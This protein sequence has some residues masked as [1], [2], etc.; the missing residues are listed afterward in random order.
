MKMSPYILRHYQAIHTWTGITSGLLLFIGFFA[1]ALV[2]FKPVISEWA[3]PPNDK[4]TQINIKQLDTLTQEILK[5]F[6]QAQKHLVVNFY[7]GVSPLTWLEKG[8][9]NETFMV[10]TQWFASLDHQGQVETHSSTNNE[11][12]YLLDMLHRTAGIAGELGHE[13]AGTYI[14]GIASFLYFIALVSGVII[15]LPTLIKRFFALRT[16]AG[17]SRFWLDS[18]NLVG[19]ASLPFH[20][21]IAI[22][23]VVFSLHDFFYGGLAKIYN[24]KPLFAMPT[25][26]TVEYK[27]D[28]LPKMSILLK[29][30]EEYAPEHKIHQIKLSG[31][32]S[33]NPFA[34]VLLKNDS[35]MMVGPVADFV[36]M[37]PYTLSIQTSSIAVGDQGLWGQLVTGFFALHFGSYGG[38]LGRWAYFTLGLMGAFLFYS[39]N[40]LWLE[41]R[42]EK[43]K[44]Q[45]RS[46]VAMASLTVGVCFGALLGVAVCFAAT[47]WLT[48]FTDYVNQMYLTLYYVTFFSALFVSFKKGAAESA[49]LFLTLLVWLCLSVP[50]TSILVFFLPNIGLWPASGF[51][52]ICLELLFTLFAGMFYW[53]LRANKRRAHNGDKNSVWAINL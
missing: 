40:L 25:P 2:M 53:A 13:Y 23:V 35:S 34:V 1:G 48:A 17:A 18:H 12:G 37:N 15:L 29:K 24:D 33:V 20:I 14:L 10:D 51:S 44:A 46:V 11:L 42:R 32:D 50:F 7:E 3:T 39:G 52:Q 27:L 26:N 30:I 16:N 49:M 19:I 36:F 41:K 45:T 43:N 21:V 8:S 31:L 22:T 28:A 5:Q 9:D 6:P 38:E 47:K 4:L